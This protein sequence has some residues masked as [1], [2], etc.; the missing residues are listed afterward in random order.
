MCKDHKMQ[1]RADTATHTS[2][3][4]LGVFCD[5]GDQNVSSATRDGGGVCAAWRKIVG[6]R[7]CTNQRGTDRAD[8]NIAGMTALHVLAECVSDGCVHAHESVKACSPVQVSDGCVL[9]HE[10]VKACSP[11][12]V[13]LTFARACSACT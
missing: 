5:C 7:S 2:S 3:H 9:A 10:I 4:T 6:W 11:V 12:L 13:E 1:R 8:D